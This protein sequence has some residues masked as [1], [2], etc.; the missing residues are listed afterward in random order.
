[1]VY[2]PRLDMLIFSVTDF[3][4][5]IF[6]E[7]NYLEMKKYE[8]KKRNKKIFEENEENIEDNVKE[9]KMY[10]VNDI[11]GFI[12]YFNKKWNIKFLYNIFIIILIFL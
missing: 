2:I 4:D 12:K 9:N 11:D 6:S 1:M 10:M 5:E 8:K 3:E 7:E